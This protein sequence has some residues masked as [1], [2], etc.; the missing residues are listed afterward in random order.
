MADR[1]ALGLAEVIDGT[2]EFWVDDRYAHD[3]PGAAYF[4]CVRL[5]PVPERPDRPPVQGFAPTRIVESLDRGLIARPMAGGKVYL[6]WRLLKDDPSS[7]AFHVYRQTGDAAP[8]RLSAS[9]LEETTDF[10]DAQAPQGTACRYT[11]RAVVSG[12]EREPCG[13]VRL[14]PSGE[15]IPAVVLKLDPGTTVQKVGVGDLDGDGRYDYVLKTPRDNIDPAG[16]Y[17][18]PSPDTYH[19]QA[20]SADGVKL[21]DHDL[22]WSI[23]RGIWYSPMIVFDLNGDGRAEVALKTGQGDPRGADGRVETGPEYLSVLDGATGKELARDDW[24]SRVIPGEPY[25]YKDRKSV[26]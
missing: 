9:P 10:V 18:T 22:G 19:L 4:D 7:V 11:V 24:P 25:N 23:E 1:N 5:A 17:W 21:W 15:P 3:P 6:G 20:Y 12:Q 26:V 16:D 8:E 2:L 14:T 13:E